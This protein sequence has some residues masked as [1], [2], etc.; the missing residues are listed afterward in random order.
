[1][2]DHLGDDGR[3]TGEHRLDGAVV[4]VAYPAFQPA[5]PCPV[6]DPGA[7]TDALHPA[8][9]RHMENRVGHVFNPRK[10]PAR[11]F[12]SASRVTRAVSSG[13]ANPF[14]FFGG[15]PSRSAFSVSWTA[16]VAAAIGAWP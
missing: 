16:R 13:D 6:L 7:V 10:A 5:R 9:D 11:C 15:M 14:R 4:A 12:V 1:M 8:A 3:G 2:R